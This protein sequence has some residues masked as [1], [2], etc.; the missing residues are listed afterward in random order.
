MKKILVIIGA[1][2]I[3][4]F[5]GIQFIPY[6]HD[7]TN[8]PVVNEPVWPDQQSQN[9]AVGACYD[10]HSNETVWPWYSNIAPVSWLI[11]RDVENGRR[12]LNFSEWTSSQHEIGEISEVLHYGTMPPTQY[13]LMHPEAKLTDAEIQILVNGIKS[14]TQSSSK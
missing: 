9:I 6:G 13:K 8:P 4:G 12:H 14:S 7:H 3:I 5:I 1:V 2:L 10:C 11:Q